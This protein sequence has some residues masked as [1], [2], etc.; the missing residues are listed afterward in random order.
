MKPQKSVCPHSTA[1]SCIFLYFAATVGPLL[2]LFPADRIV[3]DALVLSALGLLILQPCPKMLPRIKISPSRKVLL[4]DLFES[5]D[6]K[7]QAR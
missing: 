7:S 1:S 5:I 4:V 3:T 2:S 6:H